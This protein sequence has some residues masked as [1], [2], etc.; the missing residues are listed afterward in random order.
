MYE[1]GQAAPRDLGQARIWYGRAAAQ[2][3]A[4]ATDALRRLDGPPKG[5][6]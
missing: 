3:I 2:N 5:G 1:L 4:A 6:Q